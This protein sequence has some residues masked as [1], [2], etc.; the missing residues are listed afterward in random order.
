VVDAFWHHLII[1]N[2]PPLGLRVSYNHLR[3]KGIPHTPF[4]K[5]PNKKEKKRQKYIRTLK[6]CKCHFSFLPAFFC[7]RTLTPNLV[8]FISY[9][10]IAL[11]IKAF[12]LPH[13]FDRDPALMELAICAAIIRITIVQCFLHRYF[14]RS[15]SAWTVLPVAYLLSYYLVLYEYPVILCVDFLPLL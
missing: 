1:Q 3:P 2:P 6:K 7:P 8:F 4:Q 13:L 14:L 10:V 12:L 11:L 15:A 5:P 9:Q